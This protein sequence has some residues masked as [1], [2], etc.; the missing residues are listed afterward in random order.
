MASQNTIMMPDEYSFKW[1]I[2]NLLGHDFYHDYNKGNIL[3]KT[4]TVS[5]DVISQLDILIEIFSNYAYI[6]D[7]PSTDKQIQMINDLKKEGGQMF[8]G[9][10]RRRDNTNL[11][12][13]NLSKSKKSKTEPFPIF[14][15]PKRLPVT[16]KKRKLS[17]TN[18]EINSPSTQRKKVTIR[19]SPILKPLEKLSDKFY[20][21][22]TVGEED[23]VSTENIDNSVNFDNIKLSDADIEVIGKIY[24]KALDLQQQEESRSVGESEDAYVVTNYDRL[25][26]L[27]QNLPPSDQKTIYDL[28]LCMQA[29]SQGKAD[30]I[31]MIPS[32]N[33][34]KKNP[35]L[36]SAMDD[37]SVKLQFVEPGDYET[38]IKKLWTPL[39]DFTPKKEE[40]LRENLQLDEDV[41]LFPTVK[42]VVNHSINKMEQQI[43]ELIPAAV[44][45]IVLIALA[46]VLN[47]ITK[48]YLNKQ[49]TDLL[50]ILKHE[51]EKTINEFYDIRD[52]DNIKIIHPQ[53][54]I[55]L[56]RQNRESVVNPRLVPVENN[57]LKIFLKSFFGGVDREI[58]I[59][60]IND[61][62]NKGK[63]ALKSY[64]TE[65]ISIPVP[66]AKTR[67]E[68]IDMLNSLIPDAFRVGIRWMQ[69]SLE[70]LSKFRDT[71]IRQSKMQALQN[72]LE[73]IKK[74]FPDKLTVNSNCDDI[75]KYRRFIRRW[76]H[77]VRPR[78]SRPGKITD[79]NKHNFYDEKKTMNDIGEWLGSIIKYWMDAEGA[80]DS[81]FKRAFKLEY[82][83]PP[84]SEK[85]I[86][87]FSLDFGGLDGV[88]NI[89]EIEY[90]VCFQKYSGGGVFQDLPQIEKETALVCLND[91]LIKSLLFVIL[92]ETDCISATEFD[93]DEPIFPTRKNEILG[94][95]GIAPTKSC[96]IN[97]NGEDMSS[98][99][100]VGPPGNP[101]PEEPITSFEMYEYNKPNFVDL[102]Y[103]MGWIQG[104][105]LA[106]KGSEWRSGNL[107]QSISPDDMPSNMFIESS[108]IAI[109]KRLENTDKELTRLDGLIE[110][111]PKELREKYKT[112]RAKLL[113]LKKKMLLDKRLAENTLSSLPE[114]NMVL[115]DKNGNIIWDRIYGN[116][117]IIP[118][119]P[120]LSLDV[121]KK[122]A[123]I[124]FLNVEILILYFQL[125]TN[126][127]KYYGDIDGEKVNKKYF[128]QSL[129]FIL[130]NTD[131]FWTDIKKR[132]FT[133]DGFIKKDKGEKNVKN[134]S[135]ETK[136]TA[137]W[138]AKSNECFGTQRERIKKCK[139]LRQQHFGWLFGD[140][141]LLEDNLYETPKWF[142]AGTPDD[143][144]Q[145]AFNIIIRKLMPEYILTA[146]AYSD[147]DGYLKSEVNFPVPKIKG[148]NGEWVKV[149]MQE[150]IAKQSGAQDIP[151][152]YI[153]NNCARIYPDQEKIKQTVNGEGRWD[154]YNLD[155]Y[156]VKYAQ[157]CPVS[158]VADGMP[159]CSI[160]KDSGSETLNRMVFTPLDVVVG[161]NHENYY[162]FTMK[163]PLNE[164]KDIYDFDKQTGYT[165]I[166]EYIPSLNEHWN[167]YPSKPKF[168]KGEAKAS[169]DEK[170]RNYDLK[171]QPIKALVEQTYNDLYSHPFNSDESIFGKLLLVAKNEFESNP[172]R[173]NFNKFIIVLTNKLSDLREKFL[174]LK[175]TAEI[176]LN[177]KFFIDKLEARGN[178]MGK[179]PF[180][181]SMR[182]LNIITNIVELLNTKA[183]SDEDYSGK[184]LPQANSAVS[185]K[186]Y[187]WFRSNIYDIFKNTI[188]KSMGDYSQEIVSSAKFAGISGSPVDAKQIYDKANYV[189]MSMTGI[190]P[191]EEPISHPYNSA[192]ESFRIFI[193]NDRPSAYRGIFF[194]TQ[195]I[196][197]NNK[198]VSGYYMGKWEKNTNLEKNGKSFLVK[199]D[200][201]IQEQIGN[202][203]LFR[204]TEQQRKKVN[205]FKEPSA[206]S[207]SGALGVSS[208]PPDPEDKSALDFGFDLDES[209]E[210]DDESNDDKKLPAEEMGSFLGGEVSPP[211]Y[212][213]SLMGGA[214]KNRKTHYNKKRR[215]NKTL[216][217]RQKKTLKHRQKKT[218][219]RRQNKH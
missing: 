160:G 93:V 199:G 53:D 8:G 27:V 20:D 80:D 109:S 59:E 65:R 215:S 195:G 181:A 175:V 134:E 68:K 182:Y 61:N 198:T 64:I 192:G 207:V 152:S 44:D 78:D 4:T 92:K 169:K 39:I 121:R 9:E 69:K 37:E 12:Q 24:Q 91:I 57:Y 16:D 154:F 171:I 54:K 18:L 55:G 174:E 85:F 131:T 77:R 173:S 155:G 205:T 21:K 33:F 83:F 158:S 116:S 145:E 166:G 219:K 35:Y 149:G 108:K 206:P 202:N 50:K 19:R 22:K 47:V 187:D 214:N 105:F 163:R 81:I 74:D 135:T 104:D 56:E 103:A 162:H 63:E 132:N 136:I 180:A 142:L 88:D 70:A 11:L 139:K 112:T 203:A 213:V 191:R 190:E 156:Q 99:L 76:Y 161:F 125:V 79:F 2:I 90:S 144:M 98:Y 212:T 146:A 122:I 17:N 186:L 10:K 185:K 217:R 89:L 115:L 34:F 51:I 94:G 183:S 120:P 86:E 172:T 100:C 117:S 196:N 3:K 128:L 140:D 96:V 29:I 48:L 177:N 49:E 126:S 176:K 95:G 167:N 107:I 133:T 188:Q 119:T 193:A 127:N 137:S 141:D 150:T 28:Q 84:P 159:L 42:V 46:P 210:S 75:H 32:E 124:L 129:G 106:T 179:G 97:V 102:N 41:R 151:S 138:R 101:N 168:N 147:V 148:D 157:Y 123:R 118:H 143:Q 111:K 60:N 72:I 40:Q 164:Y 13:N 130:D 5:K 200:S 73:N 62:I 23:E 1:L 178:L 66:N 110:L 7:E 194:I 87:Q 114:N 113:S 184:A 165:K 43:T 71:K 25:G 201:V 14:S 36:I 204:W 209:D 38:K 31:P 216:K 218:L 170:N 45:K 15:T 52:I 30:F 189:S 208:V 197:I 153:I 26:M 6:A 67:T 211:Q 82:I 58:T